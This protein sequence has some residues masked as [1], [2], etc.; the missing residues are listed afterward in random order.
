MST[1]T[2]SVF[3]IKLADG[4]AYV[5]IVQVHP[6][7]GDILAVDAALYSSAVADLNHLTFT[8][9][10]IF[11]LQAA[12]SAKHVDANQIGR[13]GTADQPHPNFKFAVR[14]TAGVPLYWWLWDGRGIAIAEPDQDLSSTPE[15][16]ILSRAEFLDLW[17]DAPQ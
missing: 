9:I 1:E 6:V 14:D 11:P 10:V 7:Y 12:S 5:Q 17:R 16:K 2:G 15:R 13:S 4:L 8:T 3:E